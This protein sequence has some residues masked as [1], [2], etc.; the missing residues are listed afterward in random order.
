MAT[1]QYQAGNTAIFITWD[2]NENSGGSNK[3]PTIVV[4]PYTIACA[5]GDTSNNCEQALTASLAS[6]QHPDA[7]LTLGDSQYNAGLLSEYPVRARMA[8]RG[9]CSTRSRVRRRATTSTR[10][11]R[12]RRATSARR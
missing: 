7:V 2:E 8:P 5:P 4:S 12:P 6:A 3:V 9:V 1:A 11:A 10:R